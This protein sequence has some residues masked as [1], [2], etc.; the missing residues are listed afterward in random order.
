[1]AQEP[2]P[3]RQPSLWCEDGGPPNEHDDRDDDNDQQE[4]KHHVLLG[5]SDLTVSMPASLP[6]SPSVPPVGEE[7]DD[8]EQDDEQQQHYARFLLVVERHGTRA[9]RRRGVLGASGSPIDECLE[10]GHLDTVAAFVPTGLHCAELAEAYPRSD[11]CRLDEEMFRDLI[12][13]KQCFHAHEHSRTY[14]TVRKLI[15]YRYQQ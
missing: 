14:I 4:K 12:D 3:E 13:G 2:S 10:V 5:L 7:P 1:V 11:G 8:E 6:V 15:Y 9:S